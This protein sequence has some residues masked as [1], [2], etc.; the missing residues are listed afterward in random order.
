MPEVGA[1][2]FV[3]P[4]CG[5]QGRDIVS[6][7]GTRQY[8]IRRLDLPYFM[9]GRCRLIGYSKRLVDQCLRSWFHNQRRMMYRDGLTLRELRAEIRELVESWINHYISTAGYCR[10]SFK[11]KPS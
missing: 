1:D 10:T 2:E 9:C 6:V 4:G 7:G 11:R 3:C 5:A 8:A